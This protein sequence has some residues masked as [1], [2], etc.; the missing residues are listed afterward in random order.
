MEATQDSTAVK[1]QE[2]AALA[3]ELVNA[4]EGRA[5]EEVARRIGDIVKEAAGVSQAKPQTPA[6]YPLMFGTSRNLF[7]LSRQAGAD[8]VQSHLSARLSHLTALLSMT[9]GAGYQSFTQYDETTQ[10]DY[11]WAC[12]SMA[13]ECGELLDALGELHREELDKA[14]KAAQPG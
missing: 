6:E 12:C 10:E 3:G 9:Y 11:L 5:R 14:S 4:A 13:K 1:A 7:A 8:D 2:I